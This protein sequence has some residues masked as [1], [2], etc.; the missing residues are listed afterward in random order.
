MG[1]GMVTIPPDGIR[2]YETIR[3]D[4]GSKVPGWLNNHREVIPVSTWCEQYDWIV[5]LYYRIVIP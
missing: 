5:L 1:E 2:Q 4:Q 3:F